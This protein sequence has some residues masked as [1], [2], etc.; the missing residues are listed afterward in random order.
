MAFDF[1]K[2]SPSRRGFGLRGF[3]QFCR[4]L[5]AFEVA[6]PA[7]SIVSFVRLFAHKCLY[8][9]LKLR[10]CEAHY[11]SFGATI[12]HLFGAGPPPGAGLRL[13]DRQKGKTVALLRVHIEESPDPAGTSQ[14]ISVLRAEPVLVTIKREPILTEANVVSAKV[15]EAG[16]VL[17]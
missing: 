7:F 1:S 13:P 9:V 14:D 16:A 17:P 12:Q 6:F 4:L 10:F 8:I 3:F 11:E 15:I 2:D 5:F